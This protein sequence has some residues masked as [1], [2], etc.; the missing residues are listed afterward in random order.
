MEQQVPK[1]RPGT[2]LIAA[3]KGTQ[4]VEAA[5]CQPGTDWSPEADLENSRNI[6]GSPVRCQPAT[7]ARR[8]AQS[9]AQSNQCKLPVTAVLAWSKA[10]FRSRVEVI[11]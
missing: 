5:Y 3:T 8:D 10:S 4:M 7:E 11:N 1:C 6:S 2:D 9:V